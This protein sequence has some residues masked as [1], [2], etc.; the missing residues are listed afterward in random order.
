MSTIAR[1]EDRYEFV[2]D[3]A[4]GGEGEV[5]QYRRKDTG[6]FVAVKFRGR[7]NRGRAREVDILQSFPKNRLIVGFVEC[8]NINHQDCAIVLEYCP[9]GD[10]YGFYRRQ[11]QSNTK[12]A[13][14]E[15]FMWS[16]FKQLA[17]AL[18]FL[19][20]SR[21]GGGRLQPVIHCDIKPNN[22]LIKSL[23]TKGDF[24]SISIRLADF[25]FA[26]FYDP[27][28]TY[29]SLFGS[30][31]YF[32]PEMDWQEPKY[33][34]ALDIWG[35]GAVMHFLA[36]G[37]P[38]LED[39][40]IAAK[41]GAEG[42]VSLSGANKEKFLSRGYSESDWHNLNTKRVVVAINLEQDNQTSDSRT[43]RPTPRYSDA[44]NKC[45]NLPLTMDAQV[46]PDASVIAKRVKKHQPSFWWS[47]LL[48]KIKCLC[49]KEKARRNS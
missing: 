29:Q 44:L 5:K 46:R 6:T 24:S 48:D 33:N 13:F 10:L 35:M 45:F 32:P 34:P 12:L 3:L 47:D 25:G 16:V 9:G 27:K 11:M 41:R 28:H 21:C 22:I 31:A 26:R 15:R 39:P 37:Y 17:D 2:K 49:N 18:A 40:D 43:K 36:H 1:L 42:N 4:K 38:P 8:F 14:S 23:G 7:K 20:S 19:H 30:S